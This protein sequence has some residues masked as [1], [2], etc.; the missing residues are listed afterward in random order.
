[1][2]DSVGA[3]RL[4]PGDT[5][6]FL[7]REGEIAEVEHRFSALDGSSGPSLIWLTGS[8]GIGKTTLAIRL[9]HMFADLFP[10][11]ALYYEL[12]GSTPAGPADAADVLRHFLARLGKKPEDIPT[13]LNERAADFRSLT[14][15]KRILVVLDD[16]HT[17][18]QV[19]S[20]LP[21][22]PRAAVIVT[23]RRHMDG[24][25]AAGFREVAVNAFDA[26]T[27]ARLVAQVVDPTHLAAEPAAVARLVTLCSGLPLA[28]RVLAARIAGR[29]HRSLGALVEQV[30]SAPFAHLRLDG[31]PSVEAVFDACFADLDA[32]HK[33]A[34]C[35]LGWHPGPRFAPESAAA[36]LDRPV[37]D[38]LDLLDGLVDAYLLQRHDITGR[39]GF[40]SL[41]ALHARTRSEEYPSYDTA[42]ARRRVVAWHWERAV[43]LG[44]VLSPRWTVGRQDVPPA[45]TG[46]DARHRAE[47]ELESDETGHRAAVHL[48]QELDLADAAAG[49]CEA[50]KPWYYDTDRTGDLI[51]ILGVGAP[52]AD[53][54]GDPRLAMRL[55][56]DLGSAY[57]K[58][59]D[60]DLAL[61]EFDYSR[62]LAR[63]TGDPLG[64]ASA[65]EWPG[66]VHR[67]RGDHDRALACFEE[68]RGILTGATTGDPA[69]RERA[70][71]LISL[72]VGTEL[73]LVGRCEDAEVELR[74]AHAWFADRDEKVNEARALAGL[75]TAR[76]NAGVAAEALPMLER[77][78]TLF[79][80]RGLRSKQAEAL[81]TLAELHAE[82]G[83]E[84]P[85]LSCANTARALAQRLGL[86]SV[87][88]R[89]DAFLAER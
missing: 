70:L 30:T 14:S 29:R 57:E 50:L 31:D 37:E 24:L 64:E 12:G 81:F 76:V 52:A 71:V 15:G 51:D 49:I 43:A 88:S 65:V 34:Y 59:G 3:P 44:R 48:A 89:I 6:G 82:A 19:R 74:R 86:W 16:A 78:A 84:Q 33:R 80:E 66:L 42:S 73:A 27:A 26:E 25:L 72:H 21:S 79:G 62:L 11:G 5:P 38:A 23:S 28:L 46:G 10:D 8:A 7:N 32:D 53:R 1:M 20:L 77:A 69:Q 75:A 87:V 55:H 58:V 40:H 83:E 39:Y 68:A 22:S 61:A 54:A 2:A 60:F 41:I 18:A 35:L 13:H 67:Q 4:L 85:A 17:A 36:L 47:V 9:G 63:A 56:H 45:Y